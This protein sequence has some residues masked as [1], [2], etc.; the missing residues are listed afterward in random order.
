METYEQ[1]KD[2]GYPWMGKIPSHWRDINPKALFTQRKERAREG[3]RQLTAS[4][5][6]GVLYQDEYMALTG[7]R[8]VVVQKDFDI[9]KHVEAG[10]FVIS[11]RSFQGGLEYSPVSGSI[12]SAYVMLIPNKELVYPPFF[13]WLLKSSAYI[14]ALQSTTDLVRDGQAMRYSNFAK[15]RLLVAPIDEQKRMAQFLDSRVAQIDAVLNEA[16]ASIEKY[17]KWKESVIF[18]KI[19]KGLDPNVT[20]KES[21]SPWIGSIPAHWKKLPLKRVVLSRDGGA[22]GGEPLSDDIDRIC[23]RVAD[24]NFEYG[25]FRRSNEDEYTKRSYSNS[26]VEKLTLR[27]GDILVEK[28]GGG[29]K[30]P[31]GRAVLFD[32]DVQALFANFMDRLSIDTNVILPEFFEYFWQAM[33]YLAITT[34]YIKQTTGIQNLNISALL[35][36]EIIVF[37]DIEEQKQIIHFLDDFSENVR[38]LIDEKTRLISDLE[39]YKKSIIY[40]VVTGKRKVE[41]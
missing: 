5:Q 41:V 40:E 34:I 38:S 14:H 25:R 23:M 39:K 4:Q 33:Y 12:S 24:F 9:L 6:Y 28:S 3:E 18:E 20:L 21:L 27:Q 7:S 37:P 8:V 36:K 31:V 30:T 2:S 32:I 19:T 13:K 35:E 1:M 22:W 10:D 29:D 11:M 26:Q 15:V 17:K 16:R